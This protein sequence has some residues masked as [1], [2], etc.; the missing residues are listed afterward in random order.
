MNWTLPRLVVTALIV[1]TLAACSTPPA[2]APSRP[3]ASAPPPMPAAA[4]LPD[5]TG[6]LPPPLVQPKSRWVPVRWSELPGVTDDALHEA[7]NAWIKSCER[8]VPPFTTLCGE[9][10]QLSIASSEEQRAWLVARLRPY[11]V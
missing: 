9:V 6:P 5:D 3:E 8:P 11:R 7:W 10:R 2:P 1:G 4:G